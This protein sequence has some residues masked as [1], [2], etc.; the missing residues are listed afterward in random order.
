MKRK[1]PELFP[2]TIGVLPDAQTTFLK[3]GIPVFII[4]AGSEEIMRV[5]FTFWAGQTR[6]NIPLQSGTTNMMLL[7]G[8]SD[9]TSEELNS[10]LDHYGA[11]VNLYAEKD[12]AGV[13]VFCLN[14]YSGKILEL[15][16]EIIFRPAFPGNELEA[17][18]NKRLQWYRIN[19]EKVQNLASDQFFESIFGSGHPYGR[20][21]FEEDFKSVNPE[22]LK[23]FHKR[24]Y[25]P[26]N[27][28]VIVS[29]K[30]DPGLLN[31]LE[32][33]FGKIQN[34]GAHHE[35]LLPAISGETLKKVHISKKGAVQCALR[36]GSA[37]INKRHKDYPGLKITDLLLG[38][39]FGSRL[40]KNLREEKGFTYGISSS[41]TSL[42]LSGYMGIGAEVGKK[43]RNRALEEIYR[44]ISIL[45]T[46]PVERK[47]LDV[48]R[49]Y[50]SGE[51]VR[52]FDGPFAIAESFRAAWEFGLDNN[53]YYTLANRI[54]TI[55]PDEITVLARTYYKIEDLYEIAAG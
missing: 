53:Y 41:V 5:E 31:L 45:Q 7:E 9:H 52:M 10:L 28:A 15:M 22:I 17:L 38:G 40:M 16:S 36:I 49:N 12:R 6:E 32:A 39:Y 42:D 54:K 21:T 34:N 23:S 51:M 24:H 29:G 8:S 55:E 33:I 13:I 30:T 44:E 48:A 27:M 11:F 35:E 26:D 4:G 47:E 20:K 43:Y 19:R 1:Q 25:T 50:M 46:Q 18:M 3:N 37:T 14:K 2:V